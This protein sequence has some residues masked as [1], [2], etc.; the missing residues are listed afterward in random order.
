[1]D[2]K[3][4][5]TLG[6]VKQCTPYEYDPVKDELHK[7]S[8]I[9]Y[10]HIKRDGSLFRLEKGIYSAYI[11]PIIK[12]T[13]QNL[14][15]KTFG[16]SNPSPSMFLKIISQMVYGC[17][18]LSQNNM[19]HMDLHESNMGYMGSNKPVMFDFGLSVS[20]DNEDPSESELTG[21]HISQ[22]NISIPPDIY[23]YVV[24]HAAGLFRNPHMEDVEDL[25]HVLTEW[26][27]YPKNQVIGL[28]PEEIVKVYDTDE[29]SQ[30]G[31]R[32]MPPNKYDYAERTSHAMIELYK[33]ISDMNMDTRKWLAEKICRTVDTYTV[34][35]VILLYINSIDTSK[36]FRKDMLRIVK[37]ASHFDILKRKWPYEVNEMM[38]EVLEKNK[39]KI[40]KK[41]RPYELEKTHETPD[42]IEKIIKSREE[43]LGLK[44]DPHGR[45][46]DDR[47]GR[48]SHRG[49]THHPTPRTR[50]EFHE[51]DRF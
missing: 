5:F 22:R 1:L 17:C 27:L 29:L 42:E 11:M 50:H 37:A 3:S 43:L 46:H 26:T 23:M 51:G 41:W 35:T 28:T 7:C 45:R 25:Q 21:C 48:M 20:F 34:G 32:D 9:E 39:V 31:I 6:N 24:T 30:I 49:S 14:I 12:G 16:I 4:A 13:L 2:P 15:D 8:V 18:V 36:E 47:S 44:D 10:N 38:D 19:I 33:H 40:P